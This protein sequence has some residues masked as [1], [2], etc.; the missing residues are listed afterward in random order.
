MF[1][2][3]NSAQ[4]QPLWQMAS[5]YSYK[6][7]CFVSMWEHL[8]H[9][10]SESSPRLKLS[11]HHCLSSAIKELELIP[12]PIRKST[13]EFTLKPWGASW[14]SCENVEKELSHESFH[15]SFWWLSKRICPVS[16]LFL[17]KFPQ[18]WQANLSDQK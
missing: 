16:S 18:K 7:R 2:Y 9:S 3:Q 4:Q 17:S 11:G 13:G 5:N 1:P 15:H 6:A 12:L 10:L 8:F 14:D